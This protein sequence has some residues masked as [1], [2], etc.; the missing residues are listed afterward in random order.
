[1]KTIHKYQS[2]YRIQLLI[3]Q[4][5]KLFF[6]IKGK[7]SDHASVYERYIDFS[8]KLYTCGSDSESIL[9]Y[10]GQI[11]TKITYFTFVTAELSKKTYLSVPVNFSERFG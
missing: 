10:Y 7:I 9:K 4:L 3:F 8:T 11:T 2:L 1:M 5:R 6:S